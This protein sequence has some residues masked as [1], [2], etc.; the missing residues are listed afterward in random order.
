[1]MI[2][3]SY[4]FRAINLRVSAL[5]WGFFA[6]MMFMPPVYMN[7]TQ[8]I[9]QGVAGAIILNGLTL[10]SSWLLF[11]SLLGVGALFHQTFAP[12]SGIMLI[13]EFFSRSRWPQVRVWA[14]LLDK[15]VFVALPIATVFIYMFGD[16]IL[17]QGRTEV[18][19][20]VGESSLKRIT[21][22]L[23][24]LA[25]AAF[26]YDKNGSRLT[27]FTVCATIF[28]AFAIPF[29][30]DFLRLQ[31]FMMPF[32]LMSCLEIK[33]WRRVVVVGAIAILISVYVTPQFGI[34]AV[35]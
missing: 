33:D 12:F 32:L 5:K 30:F 16:V 26:L 25:C 20:S 3:A 17:G 22:S 31:T 23:M 18:Y 14:P 2:C 4:I 29:A 7:Y 34:S 10:S 15:A 1:M 9:R 28:V 8:V 11:L 13:R 27:Y 6:I 24:L 19:F 35:L 21:V